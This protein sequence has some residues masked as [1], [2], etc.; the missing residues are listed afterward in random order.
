ML[1]SGFAFA[2]TV[3]VTDILHLGMHEMPGSGAK[4]ETLRSGAELKVL[5]K[6]RKHTKVRTTTGSTGWAKS[7]YLV[8]DKPARLQLDEFMKKNQRLVNELD[9]VK[10]KIKR[11]R[12]NLSELQQQAKLVI[13]E[14]KE[15]TENL[16]RLQNENK[17][18]REHMATYKSSVPFS[19]FMSAIVIC[20]VTGFISCY[21]WLDYQN[22]KR[23]GGFLV[24]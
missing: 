10:K 22:R 5:E 14:S 4:V 19:V 11:E 24:R 7:A 20:L 3:Y 1:L 21:F 8:K 17:Q 13:K 9:S 2:E 18:F 12:A 16:D 15:Q 6:T 23:H